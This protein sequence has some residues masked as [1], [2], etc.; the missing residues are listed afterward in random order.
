[1]PHTVT[2]KTPADSFFNSLKGRIRLASIALAILNC[3]IGLGSYLAFSSMLISPATAI[4]SSIFAMAILTIAFGLWLSTEIIRPVETLT[5]LARSLERSPSAA[6][7]STTGSA[8]TDELLN[9]LQRSSRQMQNLINLMDDVAAGRTETAF[10]PL[11][12]AD[13]LSVSFQKLVSKVTDSITAKHEL[14]ELTNAVAALSI[15]AA[16]ARQMH[17]DLN[18]RATNA[19]L[20]VIAEALEFLAS[21]LMRAIQEA[22]LS[23]SRVSD[24][25]S[26]ARGLINEAL[27]R[28]E[29]RAAGIGSALGS[30]A[31]IKLR[32]SVA[33][34]SEIFDSENQNEVFVTS[35]S[36]NLLLSNRLASLK[37]RVQEV[38][39]KI[40]KFRDRSADLP[41]FARSASEMARRANLIALNTTIQDSEIAASAVEIIVDE[42][43]LLSDRSSK[44][45]AELSSLYESLSAEIADLENVLTAANDALADTIRKV[46]VESTYREDT[47]KSFQQI[48]GIFRR[49]DAASVE[50]VDE[51]NKLLSA[52]E[53]LS[54]FDLEQSLIERAD[55]NLQ[56]A[57]GIL[58]E[59]RQQIASS[60][61]SAS[62]NGSVD[63]QKQKLE[64]GQTSNRARN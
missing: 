31:A 4:A 14:D 7:P 17:L 34:L 28:R 60:P 44:L 13:R 3:A 57:T 8:E 27:A 36:T 58:S 50:A 56:T 25:I 2:K 6:L 5:L 23:G 32:A 24:S 59:M 22:K 43:S 41:V 15:E 40:R 12:N 45:S 64:R 63:Y 48:Q 1:M 26:E 53:I 39:R 20:A 37:N 19:K 18:F 62:V 16:E 9:V 46:A 11:E 29:M 33:Q 10:I 21:S 35:D 61:L 42:L 49:I 52:V 38:S 55:T 54:D 30:S 47:L 51:V